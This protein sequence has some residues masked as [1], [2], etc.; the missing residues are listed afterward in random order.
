MKK[1]F[2]RCQG[3]QRCPQHAE[4]LDGTS[5]ALA[6]YPVK[7]V[8]ALVADFGRHL[9]GIS[10]YH[11]AAFWACKRCQEGLIGGEH[12][13]GSGC[14]L[15][16]GRLPAPPGGIPQVVPTEPEVDFL[17]EPIPPAEGALPALLP[18]E[19]VAAADAPDAVA[20]VAAPSIA[21]PPPVV[22]AAAPAP[23]AEE[24]VEQPTYLEPSFDIKS[25]HRKL[26]DPATSVDEKIS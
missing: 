21:V 6:V 7:M 3:P 8:D 19:A 16:P 20:P 14:R 23:V 11:S 4:L 12:T 18:A 5:A 22:P 24:V 9:H 13:Y 1:V 2:V 10:G 15:Q 26:C 17:G 25:L